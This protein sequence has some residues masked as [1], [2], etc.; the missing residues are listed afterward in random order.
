MAPFP[1]LTFKV[2]FKF[3]ADGIQLQEINNGCLMKLMLLEFGGI[4]FLLAVFEI[5][6]V[7]KT[8]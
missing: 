2:W 8:M 7:L 6:V 4:I 3:C 1:I 5:N